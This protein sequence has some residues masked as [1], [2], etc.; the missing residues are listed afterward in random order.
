MLV[1]FQPGPHTLSQENHPSISVVEVI[2]FKEAVYFSTPVV[3]SPQTH[4]IGLLL[5]C[6]AMGNLADCMVKKQQI[7]QA[8]TLMRILY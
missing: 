4:S 1:K 3:R 6:L 8:F 7:I 2:V 5:D